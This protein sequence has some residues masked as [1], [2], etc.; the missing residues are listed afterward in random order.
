M[1]RG[2]P[3]AK[4]D[5]LGMKYTTFHVPLQANPKLTASS[6]LRYESQSVWTRNTANRTRERVPED[7]EARRG[8]KVIVIHPGSRY[9]RIGRASDVVPVTIPHVIAR[10][11]HTKP[12]TPRKPLQCIMR[13]Q[14][15]HE[16]ENEVTDITDEYAV[17]VMSDDPV[18]AKIAAIT[19]SLRDR[20]RFYQLHV[21]PNSLKASISFNKMVVPEAT[22]DPNGRQRKKPLG[23]ILVGEDVVNLPDDA[24]LDG[25]VMR[26]PIYAGRFNTWDYTSHQNMLSDIEEIWRSSIQN[27]LGIE[28]NAFHEYSVVLVIPDIWDRFYV[29]ELINL[30]LVSMRFKQVTCQQES[31]ASTYG[32]GISNA[33]VID[34]GAVKTNVSCVDDGLVIADTR[35]TLSIGG[36][37]VT[38]F[39][40]VLLG[41]INFPYK[42]MDLTRFHDWL[43][44]EELKCRICTL[45]EMDVG[46][47]IFD[48][49]VR[50]P[51][52]QHNKFALRVYDEV[53]L[54]PMLIFEP[55]VVDF[56]KK[57]D[58]LR[59]AS[60]PDISDELVESVH[61]QLTNAMLI[62]TQHLIPQN[63]PPQAQVPTSMPASGA[64]TPQPP[65]LPKTDVKGE[66][67]TAESG[68]VKRSD[69]HADTVE[70]DLQDTEMKDINAG[71]E[72]PSIPQEPIQEPRQEEN[73]QSEAPLQNQTQNQQEVPSAS[74]AGTGTVESTSTPTPS[75]AVIQPQVFLGGYP[76]DVPFEASKLPLDVAIFNSARAAGGDDRIRKYLQAVLVVGGGALTTGMVHALESR[77]Q[78][79][80]TPLVPNM[81]K[82]QIIPLPKDIDPR[83]LSWKGAAVLGKMDAVADF[84]VTDTDWN[85]FGM[86]ALKERCFYL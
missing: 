16:S 74:P 18:E 85:R 44:I 82:V 28:P 14:A 15:N 57:R 66:A 33:C 39:L 83:N 2:I 62:S 12:V 59:R 30:L 45:N 36:D 55:R 56:E 8:S 40:Y 20:M 37:D 5:D 31:L 84:W 51:N 11:C 65:D 38:E 43:V 24:H 86:R 35:L 23:D 10:K 72:P 79:I 81:E 58:C 63:P 54:A 46:L 6:Y 34:L 13:P 48:F 47:N 1:P 77:L 26:W 21:T 61:D 29:H 67:A 17:N 64:A 76:I 53:I 80:A 32:A 68:S 19:T 4:K 27:K 73:I 69:S 78:A 52:E 75:G 41:R 71:A 7:G 25:Y 50:R 70:D 60:H 9:L 3:N 49:V 42:E 22:P